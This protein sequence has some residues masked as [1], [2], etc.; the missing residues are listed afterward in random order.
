MACA[1]WPPGK[2]DA[3]CL[4]CLPC[5]P[6]LM[7]AMLFVLSTSCRQSPL[8]AL[9]LLPTPAEPRP[10]EHEHHTH[11]M[12]FFCEQAAGGRTLS[13]I[14]DTRRPSPDP[15]FPLNHWRLMR[16][17][18]LTRLS[19]TPSLRY[20][21]HT[22]AMTS[23]LSP[24][25]APSSRIKTMPTRLCHSVLRKTPPAPDFAALTLTACYHGCR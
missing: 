7:L 4:P 1:A 25:H 3:E 16:R 10:G 8:D 21:Q 12:T 20:G 14:R 13:P 17:Y 15:H 11:T 5:L 24:G 18:H 6:C 9:P 19:P 23:F 22:C 2:L